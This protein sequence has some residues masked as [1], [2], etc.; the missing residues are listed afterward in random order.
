MK[1]LILIKWIN[2][3]INKKRPLI[4]PLPLPSKKDKNRLFEVRLMCLLYFSRTC[5]VFSNSLPAGGEDA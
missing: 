5:G 4:I 3:K 1:I 2:V